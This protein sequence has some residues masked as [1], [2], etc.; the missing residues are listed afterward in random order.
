MIN[1]MPTIAIL[2]TFSDLLVFSI[3]E[4]KVND[5]ALQ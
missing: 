4:G 1:E 3:S 2:E 5:F